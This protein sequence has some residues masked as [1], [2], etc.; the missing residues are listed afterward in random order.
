[1]RMPG[2]AS[3]EVGARS[4]STATLTRGTKARR[5]RGSA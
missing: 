1:L 3:G 5:T 4:R 2:R